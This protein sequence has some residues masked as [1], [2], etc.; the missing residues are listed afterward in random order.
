VPVVV[1]GGVDVEDG[2]EGNE[3]IVVDSRCRRDRLWNKLAMFHAP[4]NTISATT[5]K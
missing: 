3:S 5:S 1:V 2:G 4:A